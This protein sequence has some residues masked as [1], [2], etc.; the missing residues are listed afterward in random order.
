[1]GTRGGESTVYIGSKSQGKKFGNAIEL[2]VVGDKLAANSISDQQPHIFLNGQDLGFGSSMYDAAGTVG[3]LSGDPSAGQYDI[4]RGTE[5]VG[6]IDHPSVFYPSRSYVTGVW[7]DLTFVGDKPAYVY[8]G[9]YTGDSYGEEYVKYGDEK[10]FSGYSV[11]LVANIG[12]KLVIKGS[13]D[14]T[15]YVFI[16]E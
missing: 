11:G 4:M 1:M 5:K 9:G 2:L 10:I 12:G 3:Y 7:G 14:R 6:S 13:K 15:D 8:R 16:E